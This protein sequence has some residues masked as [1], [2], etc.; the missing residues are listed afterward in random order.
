MAG[1]GLGKRV[2][3]LKDSLRERRWGEEYVP[4]KESRGQ[5]KERSRD[6]GWPK[7]DGEEGIKKKRMGKNERKRKAAATEG[8]K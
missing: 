6:S 2:R 3:D 4:P 7:K 1:K 5:G 8:G